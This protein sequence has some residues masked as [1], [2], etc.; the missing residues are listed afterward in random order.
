MANPD[1][2]VTGLTLYFM[3]GTRPERA[4]IQSAAGAT[5][6]AG[7]RFRVL[8]C[9]GGAEGWTEI[10]AN[11]L[12]FEMSGLAP[13]PPADCPDPLHFFGL[14]AAVQQSVPEWE[15]VTI[16]PGHHLGPAGSAMFPVVRA[17]AG[18]V[19]DL[20]LALPVTGIGWGPAR[21]MM[22]PRYYV[23][24]ILNWL[25]GGPFPALGMAALVPG[26]DGAMRSEGLAHFIGQEI[27]VASRSGETLSDTAKI[28]V[29]MADYLVGEGK[30]TEKRE[31]QFADERV[32]AEPSQHAGLVWVWRTD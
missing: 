6:E 28:A 7:A 24:A 1:S 11:G 29:R 22:E 3:P 25:G 4:D 30:L 31:W 23:R 15:A 18:I 8:S 20:A 14:A 17:M 13:A 21:T 32:V 16:V 26:N 9:E 27:H 10:L 19:A 5:G 12:V 2:P